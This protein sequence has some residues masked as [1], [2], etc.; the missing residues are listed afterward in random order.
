[1]L[2][3]GGEWWHF[4]RYRIV[5]ELDD[6]PSPFGHG[7][8]LIIEPCPGSQLTSYSISEMQ[9]RLGATRPPYNDLALIGA[10][11]R[12]WYSREPLREPLEQP[13]ADAPR[14]QAFAF[15][16]MAEERRER[17]RAWLEEVIDLGLD[18]PVLDWCKR[19]GLLGTS[20][21]DGEDPTTFEHLDALA[22]HQETYRENFLGFAWSAVTMDFILRG[23]R[24]S[25]MAEY[26]PTEM[27]P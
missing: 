15:I 20:P 6:D 11:L 25:P 8:Q 13:Q 26:P 14:P 21:V 23:L 12:D 1:M 5:L 9:K 17:Q 7:D 10:G 19:Y 27:K 3:L 18:G 22:A 16:S 2:V 4:D 24:S